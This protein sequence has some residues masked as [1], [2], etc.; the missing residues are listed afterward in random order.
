VGILTLMLAIT[1]NE[2][3]IDSLQ[4][5]IG[6][7]LSAHWFKAK[8]VTYAR[9]IVVLIN[10]P[11]VAVATRGYPV[12][13]LFLITNML[14]TCWF[15]PVVLGLWDSAKGRRYVT[16]EPALLPPMPAPHTHLGPAG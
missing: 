11:L 13:S 4:N 16:G 6:A 14:C 15:I 2:S 1:M 10:I 9:V 12:L 8:P 3:A 5:G 7:T